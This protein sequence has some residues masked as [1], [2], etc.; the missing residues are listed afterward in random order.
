V[1]EAENGAKAL[2]LLET[3]P[4][5]QLVLTDVVMPDM[6]GT[7][8]AV[9]VRSLRPSLPILFMSGFVEHA[10]VRDVIAASGDRLLQKP[11]TP[12]TLAQKVREALDA[13]GPAA[14]R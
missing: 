14:R 1:I 2:S 3:R 10:E 4:D 6:S 12:S 9:R 5:I 7:A 8:L 11:F 13:V